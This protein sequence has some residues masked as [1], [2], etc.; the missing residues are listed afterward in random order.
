MKSL[1]TACIAYSLVPYL[2]PGSILGVRAQLDTLRHFDL[3]G[4][5]KVCK[6]MAFMDIIMG[7][8][9]LFYILLGFR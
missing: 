2:P 9:L 3:P 1:Y 4:P 8:G 7:L 5:P 6:I